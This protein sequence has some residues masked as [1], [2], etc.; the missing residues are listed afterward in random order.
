MAFH[1]TK[2]QSIQKNEQRF[3]E[4]KREEVKGE[5]T[6]QIF[7]NRKIQI[8]SFYDFPLVLFIFESAL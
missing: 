1:Q 2:D 5:G 3:L 8:Y 7:Q 6:V 4:G